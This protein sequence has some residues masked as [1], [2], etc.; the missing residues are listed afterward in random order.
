M[1]SRSFDRKF[2]AEFLES[3][4]GSPG[5]YLVYNQQGELIYVG[6]AINLRRRLAQYRHILRRKKHRRM[7]G[8]VQEA[9]RIEIQRSDTH[10]DACLTETR[11]IQQHRP[12][13]NIVGAYSFLYPLI[14]IRSTDGDIEFCL[15][16]TPEA[17]LTAC[18]GFEFHGAFRSRRITGDAF[19]ALMALLRFVG[20]VNPSKLNRRIPRY[21]Y[22]FS[23]RRLPSTWAE[24]WTSFYK[25]ESALAVEELILKL[26]DRA[27]ARHSPDKVQEHLDKLKR[28]WRLEAVTLANAR[29]ATGADEWPVP[30]SQR[31]VVFLAYRIGASQAQ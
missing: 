31:D 29:K 11:L 14:G 15:T 6:K 8:I 18:P 17:V 13:W 2:G 28:F 9:A 26:A 20:H 30:Q 19:F 16:T 1:P 22:I 21:S 25:G 12:R 23:Y 7:R 24:R 4:P 27:G 5:V 3:L 10:L